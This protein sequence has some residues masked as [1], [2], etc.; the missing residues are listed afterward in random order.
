MMALTDNR[1]DYGVFN[2]GGGYP[3]TVKEF[4]GIVRARATREP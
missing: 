2:V 3:Y 1:M 4:A